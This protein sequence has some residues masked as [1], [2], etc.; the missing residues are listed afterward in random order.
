MSTIRNPD[1]EIEVAN[2]PGRN[3]TAPT[4][5]VGDRV[6]CN[7]TGMLGIVVRVMPH[8]HFEYLQSLFVCYDEGELFSE[9]EEPIL[10]R[11]SSGEV[12][13]SP[14]DE[15]P[16]PLED[17]WKAAT[18]RWQASAKKLRYR[19]EELQRYR[20]NNEPSL[21]NWVEDKE[22]NKID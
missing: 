22:L 1:T 5:K 10:S 18:I 12:S 15:E 6:Q 14:W 20:E 11:T 16:E 4:Y 13:P 19:I 3:S 2:L 7:K 21:L 9:E 8:P 17:A